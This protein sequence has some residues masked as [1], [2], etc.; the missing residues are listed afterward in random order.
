VSFASASVALALG[1][2]PLVVTVP[3]A[4]AVSFIIMA[5]SQKMGASGDTTIGVASTG[6]LAVGL[7][8]AALS[9]GFSGDVMAFMFGSVIALGNSDVVMAAALSA[10]VIALYVIFFKRLFLICADKPF[11]SACGVNASAYMFLVSALTALTVAV[12][13]RL[14]GSLLISALIIIPAVAARLAARSFRAMAAFSALIAAAGFIFGMVFSIVLSLPVGATVVVVDLII[15]AL[16]AAFKRM[17]TAR[18]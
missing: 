10:V 5:A 3:A 18:T 9:G 14:L 4:L 12:G 8:A 2:S 13:M 11:A 7:I 17:T 6:A 1:L 15:L 16:V